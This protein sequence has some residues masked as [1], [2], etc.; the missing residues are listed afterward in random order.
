M[1]NAN[2]TV[3]S[4]DPFPPPPSLSIYPNATTKRVKITMVQ[5]GAVARPDIKPLAAAPA[6]VAS[7][8]PSPPLAP[9]SPPAVDPYQPSE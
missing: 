5:L 8:P 1:D 9:P 4:L 7:P 6:A 3:L 2:S